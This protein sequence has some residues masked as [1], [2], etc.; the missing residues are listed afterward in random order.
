MLGRWSE[1]VA[2]AGAD[3]ALK[4]P[5]VRHDRE[6]NSVLLKIGLVL[7]LWRARLRGRHNLRGTARESGQPGHRSRR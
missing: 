4:N 2:L 7:V 1:F 5:S 6:K 3:P